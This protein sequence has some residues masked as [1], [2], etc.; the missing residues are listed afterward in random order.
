MAS[1]LTD[2]PLINPFEQHDTQDARI[3][4]LEDE[5][6]QQK[7]VIAMLVQS[8]GLLMRGENIRLDR[9]KMKTPE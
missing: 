2:Q 4:A 3:T 1:S 8:I 7:K 9:K 5:L 6:Q